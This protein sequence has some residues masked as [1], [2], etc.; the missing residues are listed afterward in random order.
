[1]K[2]L[3]SLFLFSFIIFNFNHQTANAQTDDD[4][5]TNN[6]PGDYEVVVSDP[7]AQKYPIAVPT[8]VNENGRTNALTKQITDQI[9]K[10]LEIA[11]L[12]KIIDESHSAKK[13]NDGE[14]VDFGRWKATDAHAIIHGV[15]VSSGSRLQFQMKLYDTNSQRLLVGKKYTV[16]KKDYVDAVHRFMDEVLKSFTGREG[17]FSSLITAA[18]GK[19]NRKQ[20]HVFSMD[21][22]KQG[23]VTNIKANNISPNF[24]RD[25]KSIYFTSFLNYYPEIYSAN[26]SGGGVKQL[27]SNKSTN[28]TPAGAPTSSQIAFAS[29][30]SG[31]TELYVMSK[32]GRILRRLSHSLNIDIAPSWS[33]D[34]SRIVF[35]SE[36]AGNLH[37]FVMGSGGGGASRLTYT[38]YQNDQPDWSPDGQKIIYTSR[39]RGAFDVFIMNSNGSQIQRLTRAEGNN[40]SPTWSPD[41]RYIAFAS[42]RGRGSGI[43][44]MKDDGSN[45]TL[46]PGTGGCVNPDWGPRIQ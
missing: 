28:I 1:M 14:N 36:R 20:I 44:V 38:G 7:S 34:G 5:N 24:S 35:A 13:G 11:G 12:F 21:G 39:D 29:S 30:K 32:T 8:L 37:L 16:A 2:F 10:D 27:T 26:T 22:I 42:S 19:S 17:P 15:V 6:D 40:E 9:K 3:T 18:C 4:N 25:G 45:Q 41:S 46:I 33:P 31:D 23:Q 43:Y